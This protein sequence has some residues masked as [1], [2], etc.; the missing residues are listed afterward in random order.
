MSAN[1]VTDVTE[2]KRRAA[3]T[4]WDRP[5]N[6]ERRLVALA[7]HVARVVDTFPPLTDEQRTR[8]AALLTPVGGG[9]RAA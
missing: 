3:R 7:E 2:T 4:R 5:D 8:L 6:V 9:Q 1:N